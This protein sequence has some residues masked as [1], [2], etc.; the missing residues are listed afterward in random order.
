MAASM[1]AVRAIL[2]AGS[3]LI[4]SASAPADSVL[5]ISPDGAWGEGR[6]ASFGT[7]LKRAIADCKNKQSKDKLGCGFMQTAI[8]NGHVTVAIMCA[9]HYAI[10]VGI[11]ERD[12]FLTAMAPIREA[13]WHASGPMPPCTIFAVVRP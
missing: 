11:N 1:K 9:E 2:T 4:A 10:G 7:A 6:G 3:L 13:T 5:V 8:S 12:A